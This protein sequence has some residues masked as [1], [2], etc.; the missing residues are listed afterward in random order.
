MV[1]GLITILFYSLSPL[2]SCSAFDFVKDAKVDLN[3][4]GR[5]DAIRIIET[6]EDGGFTL[7]INKTIITDSL[8]AEVDGFIIVDIDTTDI[9]KEVAVHTPGESDDDEYVIYWYDGKKIYQMGRISRWPE[10]SGDG[11]V[12]VDDWMGFWRKREIYVLDKE[13]KTLSVIPQEFY[14]VGVEAEVK[15]PFS[16]NRS[17][18]DEDGVSIVN[19]GEKIILLLYSPSK[20]DLYEDWYQ[21]KTSSGFIGWAKLKTFYEKVKGL[22]WA[23]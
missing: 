1:I 13:S 2:S 21:I 20:E 22:P 7:K 8:N 3:G 4:D 18:V 16:L 11:K 14:Y 23:D 15:D 9:F 12:L 10:F 19:A 17:R 5:L 6:N